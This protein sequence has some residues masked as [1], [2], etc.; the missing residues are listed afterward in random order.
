MLKPTARL[1][2]PQDDAPEGG[3]D[4]IDEPQTEEASH[5]EDEKEQG[6]EA[7]S[8]EG[9]LTATIGEPEPEEEEKHAPGWVRE[10]R[11]ENREKA[12]KL[13]EYEAE[14]Q[15]LRGGQEKPEPLKK[16][17]LADFD[18]DEE[19]F[20]EAVEKYF[21]SKAEQD[22]EQEKKRQAEEETQKEWQARQEAYKEAKTRF[23]AEEME[24]AESE[25][26]SVLS[27]ARQAMLLDVADDPA[28]LVLALGKNPEVLRRIAAI[29]SD[30][31]AIK[32]MVKIEMN[33]KVTPKGKTPPPPERTISG[34]GKTAGAATTSLEKLKETAERTGDYTAYYA[35]KRRQGK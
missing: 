19:K 14:L 34:S 4:V 32:E 3:T 18:Y 9:E 13:K 28:T 1:L 27:P 8:E 15:R 23:S 33:I 20:E 21:Q 25:V 29:K 35:E 22:K 2:K 11:K 26:V 17:Q 30:G 16:P 5:D 6:Q 12:K 10:L 24:D 7:V 31:Q